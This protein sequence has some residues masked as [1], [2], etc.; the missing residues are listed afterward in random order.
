MIEDIDVPPNP[1]A[2]INV[3]YLNGKIMW[4]TGLF[5]SAGDSSMVVVL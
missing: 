3:G 2:T 4:I 1:R 5:Y